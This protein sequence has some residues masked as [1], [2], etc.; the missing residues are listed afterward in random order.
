[1]SD[2]FVGDVKVELGRRLRLERGAV[3]GHRLA[4]LDLTLEPIL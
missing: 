1:M 4:D 2:V 3:D